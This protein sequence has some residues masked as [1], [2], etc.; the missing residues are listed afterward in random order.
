M[1]LDATWRRANQRARTFPVTQRVTFHRVISGQ[2]QGITKPS[3]PQPRDTHTRTQIHTHQT[4][5]LRWVQLNFVL[6]LIPSKD[7]QKIWSLLISRWTRL[8]FRY[9]RCVLFCVSPHV[10]SSRRR[11]S[12]RF[13]PPRTRSFPAITLPGTRRRIARITPLSPCITFN[14]AASTQPICCTICAPHGNLASGPAC[15]ESDSADRAHTLRTGP[16]FRGLLNFRGHPGCLQTLNVGVF[17]CHGHPFDMG[18]CIIEL[19][20]LFPACFFLVL[21]S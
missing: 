16:A 8:H 4:K 12:R 19:E 11:V 14:F 21:N 2:I 5:L 6:V 13:D 9:G 3:P 18:L 7:S 20:F 15:P 10:A 17:S 1:A